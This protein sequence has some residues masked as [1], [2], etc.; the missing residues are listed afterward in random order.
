MPLDQPIKT[1]AEVAAAKRVALAVVRKAIHE[2]RLKAA[3]PGKE[4]LIEDCDVE[5]WWEAEKCLCQQW[6]HGS[7]GKTGAR[8]VASRNGSSEIEHIAKVQASISVL[9]DLRR[10]KN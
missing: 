8:K 4:Y 3:K 7:I 5:A 10:N 2:G 6:A 9:R 1:V